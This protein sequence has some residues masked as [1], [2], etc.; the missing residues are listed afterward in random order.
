MYSVGE[1]FERLV[2]EDLEYLTCISNVTIGDKEY[3]ICENE[4]GTKRLFY[5]D[6]LEEDLELLE[7]EEA[8]EVLEVWE[9]EYYGSDKD[10]MY[11]NEEFGEYDVVEKESDDF[12]EI[13][14]EDEDY[15]SALGELNDEDIDE[16]LND[17]LE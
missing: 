10:Y 8:D 17:F 4:N 9:E 15:I 5:Y 16:F 1:E 11:W 13:D 2:E 14:S 12:V 7:E 6:T 3:L